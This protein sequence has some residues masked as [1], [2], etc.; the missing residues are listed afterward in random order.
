MHQIT[1]F[2]GVAFASAFGAAATAN[3]VSGVWLTEPRSNGAY[4]S[5]QIFPCQI[6][7]EQRCGKVVGAHGGARPDLIGEPILR[8]LMRNEEDGWT[9]GKIISPKSGDEYHSNIRLVDADTLEVEGC[10][11]GGLICS[12][13]EWTRAR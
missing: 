3:E 11:A 5:V 7:P 13:Q 12:G 2:S 1:T 9:D 4:I 10:V 8:G 6:N